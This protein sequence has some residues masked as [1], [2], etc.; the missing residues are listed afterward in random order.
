[1]GLELV[2]P[3]RL[4]LRAGIPDQPPARRAGRPGLRPA[5]KPTSARL[6]LHR[7]ADPRARP[8][9]RPLSRLTGFPIDSAPAL[10]PFLES[11]L[12]V[13]AIRA[14]VAARSIKARSASRA[15]KTRQRR[16]SGLRRRSSPFIVF[17]SGQPWS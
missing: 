13:K 2:A 3:A 1:R 17:A 15:R 8:A 16:R 7:A 12:W 10:P 6:R 4:R 9:H 11:N 14:A 5:G